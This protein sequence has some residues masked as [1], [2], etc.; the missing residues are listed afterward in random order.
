MVR[1]GLARGLWS[2]RAGGSQGSHGIPGAR[3]ACWSRGWSTGATTPC[4]S[5]GTC[6][7]GG[8]AAT[9]PP[10]TDPLR[11]SRGVS[12]DP[13]RTPR[14]LSSAAPP[15]PDP[16]AAAPNPA[17][18]RRP[19]RWPDPRASPRTPPRGGGQ[20]CLGSS[21]SV[22][23]G[24]RGCAPCPRLPTDSSGPPLWSGCLGVPLRPAPTY[25]VGGAALSTRGRKRWAM[26]T[27]WTAGGLAL[28]L[29]RLNARFNEG[30]DEAG[31]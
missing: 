11:A 21:A 30:S 8:C 13:P 4:L 28:T 16:G 23:P 3:A 1:V 5:P 31:R 14:H 2:S 19:V 26:K 20:G 25:P 12:A 10:W 27:M 9:L 29:D 15:P 6:Q 7:E 24:I 17:A 18:G 22:H